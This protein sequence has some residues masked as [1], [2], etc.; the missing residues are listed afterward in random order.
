MKIT[1]KTIYGL[2]ALFEIAL[3]GG[4]VGVSSAEI[5]KGQ[6]IPLKFLEQILS[7]LKRNKL[8]KSYRGRE[9]GYVLSRLPKEI[10]LLDAIEALEGPISIT[11]AL[12]R[13]NIVA[14]ILKGIEAELLERLKSFT[15]ADLVEEKLKKEKVPV[16]SI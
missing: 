1:T 16:Y 3:R 14:Q 6:K 2:Q 7:I 11:G 8:V 10:T 4:V 5:A 15:F 13:E 12:K 9:G